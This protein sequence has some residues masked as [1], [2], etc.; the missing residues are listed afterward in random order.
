MF[1]A[2]LVGAARVNAIERHFRL[3]IR[4]MDFDDNLTKGRSLIATTCFVIAQSIRTL[5]QWTD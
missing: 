2:V 1:A 5:R 4:T 3:Q